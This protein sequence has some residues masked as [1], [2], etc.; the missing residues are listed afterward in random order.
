MISNPR[1]S[2]QFFGA[3]W[4]Q[5]KRSSSVI[6]C[7]EQRLG[8]L[9]KVAVVAGAAAVRNRRPARPG[10]DVDLVRLGALTA[11]DFF[12]GI[13]VSF[14][15]R[16]WLASG[17]IP[18]VEP[19]PQHVDGGR[20]HLE[21]LPADEGPELLAAAAAWVDAAV[22]SSI[23][24][25]IEGWLMVGAPAGLKLNPV[26]TR[27][28][29]RFFLYHIH[30][31]RTFL[32]MVAMSPA[33]LS[34]WVSLLHLCRW[35]GICFQVC[36][37]RDTFNVATFHVHCFYAYARRI[38]L[39]QFC[40]LRSLWR[41]FRGL[42]F[43]PLRRRVDSAFHDH[44]PGL[45]LFVGTVAFTILL[46]LFP[47]ILV[48]FAVFGA[49]ECLLAAVNLACETFVQCFFAADWADDADGDDID[50]GSAAIAPGRPRSGR[51]PSNIFSFDRNW[52]KPATRG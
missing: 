27:S 25:L 29:G 41:L 45:L 15:V 16:S 9:R 48:Y 26:L 31:W 33:L 24:H 40:A 3:T 35:T 21:D 22:R 32:R 17:S 14:A 37:V 1:R 52:R 50:D 44:D 30:L 11:L 2:A 19:P 38:F 7:L 20:L 43:N 23:G 51:R 18:K 12:L 28:L 39:S 42:K 10:T 46:F 5:A 4:D 47:T 49:L 8:T 36:V 13:L 34:G 6:R